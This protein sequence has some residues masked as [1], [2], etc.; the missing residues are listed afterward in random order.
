MERVSGARRVLAVLILVGL[1]SGVTAGCSGSSA[2]QGKPSEATLGEPTPESVTASFTAYAKAVTAKDGG[3]SADLMS[4][5]SR[6][7]YDRIRDLAVDATPKVLAK[8]RLV[9]Q[10]TVLSMRA[11]LSPKVLRTADARSLISSAVQQDLISQ[12]SGAAQALQQVKISGSTASAQLVV[13]GGTTYP[14]TFA[15][16]GGSWR[17]DVTSLLAPAETAVQQAAESQKLSA[18]AL[19]DQVLATRVG[20]D[21]AK[22]L[23][24]PIGRG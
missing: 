14:V 2:E 7:Y 12:N 4:T 17:F 13:G 15:F 22:T 24:T 23:W 16:E 11:K 10:I 9:D 5:S 8:E 19:V 18:R 20:E 3:R 21:R 1:A 6:A